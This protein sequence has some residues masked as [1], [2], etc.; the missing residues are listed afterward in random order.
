MSDLL[1]YS[2]RA[3]PWTRV[4]LAA[5]LVAVLME[6]VRWHAWTLWP[7]EGTAVG[8]LAGAS[9]WCSDEQCAVVVD[10]APRTL[11]WRTVARL[12]GAGVLVAVWAVVVLHSREALFG[13]APT[14]LLHGVV[15]VLGGLGW[16]TWRRSAGQT[17]PGLAA[18][19]VAVP[20]ATAWALIRPWEHRLPVFP[21]GDGGDGGDGADWSGSV[22]VWVVLG[23]VAVAMLAVGVADRGRRR[24]QWA[25]VPAWVSAW[26]RSD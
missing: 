21:Y 2:A 26:V 9:A 8:L 5:L 17:M 25:W 4:W 1:T 12:P 18:A 22:R 6:L 13:H 23:V 24:A 3:V 15:A 14:V 11:R 10:A 20:L 19:S 7:L 16:S